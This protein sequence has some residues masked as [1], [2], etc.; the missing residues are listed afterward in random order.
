MKLSKLH[1]KRVFITSALDKEIRI[2]YA[3]RVKKSMP[4]DWQAQNVITDAQINDQPLFK[5]DDNKTPF[6]QLGRDMYA[7][8][9]KRTHTDEEVQALVESIESQARTQGVQD[10]ATT[11]TD[12]FITS[13]CHIGSKSISHILLAIEK[14]KDRLLAIGPASDAARLQVIT[15][16]ADYWQDHPGIAV[17]IIDKLLNY[18][19]LTPVSVVQWTLTDHM[20]SGRALASTMSLELISATMHKVCSRMRQ[21]VS[22]RTEA[23]TRA[24]DAMSDTDDQVKHLDN[25]LIEERKEMLEL[26]TMIIDAVTP[27]AQAAQDGMIEDFDGNGTA[28]GGA[29][30]LG[31][32]Q[33]WGGRWLKM[34]TRRLAVEEATVGDAAVQIRARVAKI[35]SELDIEIVAAEAQAAEALAVAAEK[36][37]QA[38][39]EARLAREKKR[40]EDMDAKATAESEA[41]TEPE[42][43][44][45]A[46]DAA[47]TDE[48]DVKADMD[49]AE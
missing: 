40:Q 23:V 17:N 27:V 5:F 30:D 2:A 25:T 10:P 15:S 13:I 24:A 45:H 43:Q 36:R 21:I 11:S 35:Q 32:L 14:S 39:T 33:A 18:T 4:E 3:Q 48:T 37:E 34:F 38:R 28:S 8:L 41:K 26:F 29:S 1:P 31:L 12:I 22:A 19:V 49:I 46:Q 9:R 44:P 6:A 20:D 7:L 16:V 42:E 47:E